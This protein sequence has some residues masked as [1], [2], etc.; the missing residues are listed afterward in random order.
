VIEVSKFLAIESSL[1]F[2]PLYIPVD[3][4]NVG[5]RT[6]YGKECRNVREL[7]MARNM[8]RSLQYIAIESS[9][10]SL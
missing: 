7:F 3:A 5:A 2:V 6:L 1:H 10:H 9:L 4:R 8:E